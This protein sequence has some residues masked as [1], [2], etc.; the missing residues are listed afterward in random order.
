MS[1]EILSGIL[2]A[3][4]RLKELKR[5]VM[6][7]NVLTDEEHNKQ[8]EDKGIKYFE[9][10]HSKPLEVS[11]TVSEKEIRERVKS[12]VQANPELKTIN[13]STLNIDNI[14]CIRYYK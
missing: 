1:P 3:C 14:K 8:N 12:V 11:R 7:T 13:I 6:D 2:K 9:M 4:S 10:H 5:V